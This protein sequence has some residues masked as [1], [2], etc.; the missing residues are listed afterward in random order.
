[1]TENIEILFS[2]PDYIKVG[3]SIT[4]EY[5]ITNPFDD[6]VDVFINI[7]VGDTLVKSIEEN[8][9][10]MSIGSGYF[11][12]VPES[13][14]FIFT[15]KGEAYIDDVL[16]GSGSVDIELTEKGLRFGVPLLIGGIGSILVG[17][18]SEHR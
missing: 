1:M 6:P 18:L 14:P 13:S 15:V 7:Y 2:M 5:T 8:V 12:M 9:D 16:V 17:G 3:E 11:T 4:I 10:P